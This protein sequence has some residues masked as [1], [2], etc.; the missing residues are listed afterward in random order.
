MKF[1]GFKAYAF[2]SLSLENSS[3]RVFGEA[4]GRDICSDE[5]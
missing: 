5:V 4:F 2:H 3:Q 1:R